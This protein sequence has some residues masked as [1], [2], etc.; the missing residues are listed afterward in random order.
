[1][2]KNEKPKVTENFPCAR[3]HAYHCAWR[4]NVN[5]QQKS[6][7]QNLRR[8]INDQT[9]YKPSTVIAEHTIQSQEY[10]RPLNSSMI[11]A[12]VR[13]DLGA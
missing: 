4:G 3:T 2:E 8:T 6:P 12:S 9:W 7:L 13:A 5:R 11:T 10:F 1:M